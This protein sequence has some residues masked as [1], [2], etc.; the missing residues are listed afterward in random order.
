MSKELQEIVERAV[1]QVLERQ[2]PKLQAELV[3]CVLA[4]LPAPAA[5]AEGGAASPMPGGLVQAIAG[6]HAGST[7]KEILKALLDAGTSYATRVALFV[8]KGGAATGWQARGLGDDDPIK[9]F[10]LDM[11]AGPASHA[12]QNRVA[13]PANI[14]EMDRRFVK[15][16]G[17]PANEQIVILPLVLK[18]KVAALLYA[19]GGAENLLDDSIRLAARAREA[20]VPV[21]LD[22]QPDMVHVYHLF[23]GFA[24]ESRRAIA[25]AAAFVRDH[26]ASSRAFAAVA[27]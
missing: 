8:V 16:F 15:Q 14:A 26:G 21:H 11:S 2:F 13:T 19:D 6:I 5:A 3:K 17:G 20:G 1:A 18:D 4:E 12:Y 24:P 7:Q 27:Q 23:A 22:V 9:D 25:T 10:P